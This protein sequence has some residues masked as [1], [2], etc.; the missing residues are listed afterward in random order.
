MIFKIPKCNLK[1]KLSPYEQLYEYMRK[2]VGMDKSTWLQQ[3]VSQVALCE[4]D[5]IKLDKDE[6]EW[7]WKNEKKLGKRWYKREYFD[8]KVFPWHYLQYSPKTDNKVE[9]GYVQSEVMDTKADKGA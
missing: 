3:S 5:A 7:H 2:K 8:K 9:K 6:K 4:Y 1:S